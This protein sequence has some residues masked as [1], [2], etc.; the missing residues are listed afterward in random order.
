MSKAILSKLS[1]PTDWGIAVLEF[2]PHR[3][4][5]AV[6]L[7]TTVGILDDGAHLSAPLTCRKLCKYCFTPMHFTAQ[8]LSKLRRKGFK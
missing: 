7:D 2:E 3:H 6:H 5:G 8:E 1:E 4:K